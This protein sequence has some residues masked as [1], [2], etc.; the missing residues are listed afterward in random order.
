MADDD[1]IVSPAS[2]AAQLYKVLVKDREDY[3][4]TIDEY[5]NGNHPEPY[6]PDTADAEFKMLAKRSITNACPLL[7]DSPTQAMYVDGY[8]RGG[9][10]VR[11]EEGMGAA[12]RRGLVEW[13]HWQ[14]SRLDARQTPVMRA[15]LTYGHSFT[16]T[17]QDAK[18]EPMTKGLSPLRTTALYEDPANDDNA[19]A[20]L[21]IRR[22]RKMVEGKEQAGKATLWDR[23]NRYEL[24]FKQGEKGMEFTVVGAPV[25]HGLEGENPVTRFAAAVDLEGRTMGVV[26]PYL[27][28]QDRINQ[29]V[30]DLLIAQTGSSFETRWVT[31]MAPPVLRD[32]E[33]DE[34]VLDENN[35][36]IPLPMNVHAKKMLFAE[37]GDARFGSLPGT[38]LEPYVQAIDMAWRHLAAVSQTPPHYLLGEVANLAAEALQMAE[39]ALHRKVTAFKNVFGES[40]ER[41]FRLSLLLSGDAHGEDMDG[42][43][44]W[45]DMDTHSL[46][47]TADALGKFRENLRIPER[48]LW[49]R[50]PNITEGELAE[51]ERLA[52]EE[53]NLPVGIRDASP[54]PDLMEDV[55]YGEG[56]GG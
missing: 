51:W 55:D 52:D 2:V 4:L 26:E 40:W 44:I 13:A 39:M 22:W 16:V 6:M 50:V 41:V 33:T 9:V 19:V 45:R 28:I 38:P 14:K 5:M 53:G 47:Q 21:T 29:T 15:A 24:T 1:N 20:V 27:R 25:P 34:P 31:G 43:V 46:A 48:A 7:V 3:L 18:G 49:K 8:R 37:D 56:A 32:P 42:E 17:E 35:Q 10:T 12:E 36:P 11:A 30:F 23:T 54:T